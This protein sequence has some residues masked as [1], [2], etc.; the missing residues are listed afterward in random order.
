MGHFIWNESYSV[1][2]GVIDEQHKKLIKII[3]ELYD[4]QKIGT[5]QILIGEVLSKLT[6]YTIYH[7]QMEEEMQSKYRFP[8]LNE[9]KEE[10]AGFVAKLNE[11]K[12]DS[13]KKNLLLSLKTLDFLKDWTITHI[14][15][16]DQEF[17][18]YLR[19]VEG[20]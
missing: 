19:M 4:A 15:G 13:E 5:T 14:L 7:F 20:G 1:G 18:D 6:D 17:A 3:N 16:S 11:L 8:N 12:K 10:H 9:H 2:I